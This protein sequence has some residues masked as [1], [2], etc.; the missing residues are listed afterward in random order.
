M[1]NRLPLVLRALLVAI[2]VSGAA[3]LVWGVLIQTNLVFFPRWPWAAA[4]MTGFLVF[5]W[6]FLKGWGWPQSTATARRAHLRAEPIASPVWR[7]SL[8]AG[9]LGLAASIALFILSHRL[10]RWPQ[11]IRPDLSHIPGV[12]LF[13]TLLMSAMVAGI[14]EEAGFR[15]YMQAPLE[16][17]Y[18][19]TLAIVFTS[20]VF[21]LAHL[22]HGFFFPA[23]LFDIAWGAL[24][25]FLAYQSGSIVPGIILHSSADALEF[26]AAWKFPRIPAPLIWGSGPDRMFWFYCTMAVVLGI[27]ALGAFR[28]LARTRAATNSSIALS[29]ISTSRQ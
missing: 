4:I 15:G 23:L 28:R 1:W 14:G 6:R 20:I 7:W 25:G 16:R 8:M 17:R 13:I 24:Y 12:T 5:Y 19:P 9:A 18:G 26:I 3:N 2:A 27:A 10:I 11:P 21:G 22:S 29:E